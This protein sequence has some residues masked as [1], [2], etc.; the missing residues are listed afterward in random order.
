[1]FYILL[2]SLSR[3]AFRNF[4]QFDIEKWSNGE[5]V[6]SILLPTH[7]APLNSSHSRVFIST[8]I[9]FRGKKC[10]NYKNAQF[11]AQKK[12][13][14]HKSSINYFRPNKKPQ[15]ISL[16]RLAVLCRLTA[17]LTARVCA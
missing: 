14:F 4:V 10:I 16:G 17:R 8:F 15:N 13:V 1:M 5:V 3:I 11:T 7:S 2:N 12:N 6:F 9:F